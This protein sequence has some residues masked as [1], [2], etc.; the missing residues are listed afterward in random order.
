[1]NKIRL[2]SLLSLA[3]ISGAAA[4]QTGLTLYGN[5]DASWVNSTGIGPGNDRRSSFGEGNWTPSVWGVSGKEDLGSGVMAHINLEGGFNAGDGSIANGGTTGVFSRQA[6]VGFSG[7]FGTFKAGLQISPFIT[8]YNSSLAVAGQNFSIPALLL[9][10]NGTA[11][12]NLGA[13]VSVANGGIDADVAS[14]TTAG[15]FIPN[16]ISYSLPRELLGGFTGSALYGFGGVPGDTG[17]NRF[18]SGNLGYSLGDINLLAAISDRA[19]QYQQYLLGGSVPLG[20]AK[21]AGSYVHFRPETGNSTNTYIIGG[22]LQV[23]PK[24]NVGI[25]FARNSGTNHPSIINVSAVYSFS[26]STEV[27][28]AFNHAKDGA[29]SPY[30]GAVDATANPAT[31]S[32]TVSISNAFILGLRK[33]F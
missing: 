24:T 1:M 4:A 11:L 19:Q 25:N 14:G 6:N 12:N 26:K 8:A 27:Y 17:A 16:S 7:D 13:P 21:L 9:H 3:L 22:G 23:M 33:G 30:S 20:A 28:A 5:I 10:R 32:Q 18:T 29:F 15:F 31:L 2:V